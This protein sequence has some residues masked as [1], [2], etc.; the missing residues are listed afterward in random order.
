MAVVDARQRHLVQRDVLPDVELGPVR[1]RERAQVLALADAGVEQI[2]RLGTLLARIPSAVAI[3]EAEDALLGA[4]FV[5]V[6]AAT[7]ERG[8][9]AVL[10]DR[11]EQRHRLQPV[12]A[13]PRPGL[14]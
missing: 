4:G 2:P 14:L 11:V 3:A 12:A 5:L 6:A 10:G 13:R 7:A 1:Q 8:V 9:E